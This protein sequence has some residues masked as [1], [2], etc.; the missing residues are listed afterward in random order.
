MILTEQDFARA[1]KI[2]TNAEKKMHLA[3]GGLG[4]ARYGDATDKIM[5]YIQQLGITTRSALLSKFYRDV[6]SQSLKGIEET[7]LQLKVIRIKLMPDKGDRV[8]EWCGPVNGSD[9]LRDRNK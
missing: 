1:R 8:Y 9:I 5:K 7:L 4:K 2:L 6:D 3:F